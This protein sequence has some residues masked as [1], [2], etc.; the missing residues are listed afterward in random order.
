VKR[1]V[2]YLL[3]QKTSRSGPSSSYRRYVVC[4]TPATACTHSSKPWTR[5]NLR[6]RH[7]GRTAVWK[8]AESVR[9]SRCLV[10]RA[11]SS[12][13]SRGS[14]FPVHSEALFLRCTR[15]T[16]FT[17]RRDHYTDLGLPLCEY[18]KAGSDG[19]WQDIRVSRFGVS[20]RRCPGWTTGVC[21]RT[22]S[23]D[24]IGLS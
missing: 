15:D 18:R 7:E 20:R 6:L 19:E 3:H 10:R 21:R 22:R 4:C 11:T 23:R 12:K 24:V 14:L 8:R 2:T 1:N 17:P 13:V 5:S 16:G 9:S